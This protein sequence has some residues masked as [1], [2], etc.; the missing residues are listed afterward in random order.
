MLSIIK[1]N[2][3]TLSTFAFGALEYCRANVDEVVETRARKSQRFLDTF[4]HLM[5]RDIYTRC[6]IE[7]YPRNTRSDMRDDCESEWQPVRQFAFG[8]RG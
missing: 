5:Y 6:A 2:C 4:H 3:L 8:K 7:Y 1:M